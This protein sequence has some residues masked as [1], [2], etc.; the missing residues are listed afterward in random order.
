MNKKQLIAL[1]IV[2]VLWAITIFIWYNSD[3][4]S[5]GFTQFLQATIFWAIF[6][7]LIFI[8]TKGDNSSDSNNKKLLNRIEYLSKNGEGI[9]AMKLAQKLEAT[10]RFTI[11]NIN[12]IKRVC[13]DGA[14]TELYSLG[15]KLISEK[16]YEKAA[17]LGTELFLII[18]EHEQDVYQLKE[19]TFAKYYKEIGEI[20]NANNKLTLAE[21]RESLSEIKTRFMKENSLSDDEKAFEMLNNCFLLTVLPQ[22]K[23]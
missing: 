2:A 15:P 19:G 11:Q 21:L 22:L 23:D 3:S 16:E 4:Y 17:K 20:V 14:I 8:S 18:F 13:H 10:E 1:W 9:E 7:G 12:E 5:W 6:G